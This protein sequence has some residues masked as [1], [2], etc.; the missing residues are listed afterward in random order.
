[1]KDRVDLIIELLKEGKPGNIGDLR[2]EPKGKDHLVVIGWSQYLNFTNIT[3]AGSIKELEEIKLLFA[4]LL[5]HSD[6]I[7]RFTINREIE[8]KLCF[9]DAG[10]TSID[11][12]T[13]RNSIVKWSI[14]IA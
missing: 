10:K 4:S 8:Y 9:D 5:R 13:E 11:I 2:L 7:R 12:C 3:I 1:M 6:E 14:K